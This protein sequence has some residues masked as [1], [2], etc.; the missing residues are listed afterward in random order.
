MRAR[1][2]FAEWDSETYYPEDLGAAVE[3]GRFC[4]DDA[5]LPIRAAMLVDLILFDIAVD[6]FYGQFATSHGR[7]TASS[8][9]SATGAA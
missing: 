4:Q 3:P 1:T 7:V 2:G 5:D 9:Q 6:S 8:I